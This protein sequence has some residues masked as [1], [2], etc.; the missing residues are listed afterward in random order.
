MQAYLAENSINA[1]VTGILEGDSFM[2]VTARPAHVSAPARIAL[3]C[4]WRQGGGLKSSL[5]GQ[6][7][8]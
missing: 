2:Q 5:R 3:A 4:T 7:W 6:L 1:K 8:R